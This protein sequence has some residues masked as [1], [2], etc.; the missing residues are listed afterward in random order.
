MLTE[1]K[2]GILTV[3]RENA[4]EVFYNDLPVA[5]ADQWHAKLQHQSL[6]VMTSTTAYAAWRYIPTTFVRCTEDKTS[7][8]PQIVDWMITTAKTTLPSC[9]QK[10]EV[11]E[12]SSHS[13][14]ISQPAALA[15][16]LRG[17]AGEE[18]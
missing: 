9:F 2:A 11:L 7:I 17:A 6:G 1:T 10:E 8:S 16:I 12:G 18:A 4:R 5:E 13:P 14:M 3:N 15:K